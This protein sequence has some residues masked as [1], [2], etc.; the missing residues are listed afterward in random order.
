[1]YSVHSMD[2]IP[3]APFVLFNGATVLSFVLLLVIVATAY[4]SKHVQRRKV[5]YAQKV[6][7]MIYCVSYMLLFGFQNSKPPRALCLLQATLIYA[8]PPACVVS[9]ASCY[10]QC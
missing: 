4:F 6:Q 8:C 10:Y 5:W 1:L 3:L 9:V 2:V 7:W